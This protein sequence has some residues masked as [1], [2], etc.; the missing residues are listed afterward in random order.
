MNGNGDAVKSILETPQWA[1]CP[2]LNGYEEWAGMPLG[3]VLE[4][5]PN[6]G[7]A[8]LGFLSSNRYYGTFP[9]KL[10][11]ALL[12]AHHHGWK[13][14]GDVHRPIPTSVGGE[15]EPRRKKREGRKTR[16]TDALV[17]AVLKEALSHLRKAVSSRSTLDIFRCVLVER[18]ADALVLRSTDLETA[19]RLT[20]PFGGEPFEAVIDAKMAYAAVMGVGA[21]KTQPVALSRE[22]DGLRLEGVRSTVTVPAPIPAS[23]FPPFPAEV[24][25]TVAVVHGL[26]L[27][28]LAAVAT[29]A[30]TEYEKRPVL[31]G[32]LVDFD[33]GNVVAADGFQMAIGRAGVRIESD[34]EV[35]SLLVPASGIEV[36]AKVM[37]SVEEVYVAQHSSDGEAWGST[38]YAILAGP[39]KAGGGGR[40]E[41]GMPLVEGEFPDYR[42]I[43]P[44]PERVPVVF[45][46]D[47]A[48]TLDAAEALLAT[49]RQAGNRAVFQVDEDD[50]LRMSV[51]GSK[52]GSQVAE[53]AVTSRRG[54]TRWGCNVKYVAGAMRR[55]KT[56]GV[57]TAA[58]R[59]GKV[60]FDGERLRFPRGV[61]LIEGGPLSWVVTT[62]D[63]DGDA[64][65][66][67][68]REAEM[69][70]ARRK[71]QDDGATAN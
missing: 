18:T 62:V 61:F 1:P 34:G 5:H 36:A 8:L 13:V 39:A 51:S 26:D 20:L 54:R 43:V 22:D 17:G 32:A 21:G 71:A 14:L 47:T 59:V 4:D 30:S 38:Y 63:V 35:P 3:K 58:F 68:D 10:A 46:V 67:R 52:V 55:L 60:G 24:S 31:T 33:R 2:S 25:R 53:V 23:E 37:V 49:S 64:H 66:W 56:L 40:M 57:E 45:Q 6:E 41:L 19:L 50:V 48:R 12:L 42:Q 15:I 65:E 44:S 27:D 16:G 29:A 69:E 11:A 28:V 9:V 7:L 70:Y